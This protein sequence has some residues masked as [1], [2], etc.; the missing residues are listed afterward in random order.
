[1]RYQK[2]KIIEDEGTYVIEVTEY[3][4]FIPA[5]TGRDP[6]DCEEAQY[7]TVEYSIVEFIPSSPEDWTGSGVDWEYHGE[8]DEEMRDED[9]FHD[10]VIDHCR[11][12]SL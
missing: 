12:E 10:E 4:P 8:W 2:M 6:L 11:N 9:Y 7:E 5:I 3:E 1:M